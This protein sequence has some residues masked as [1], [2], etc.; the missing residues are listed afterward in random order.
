[1]DLYVFGLFKSSI[2]SA[3]ITIHIKNYSLIK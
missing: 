3:F 1:M 2:G